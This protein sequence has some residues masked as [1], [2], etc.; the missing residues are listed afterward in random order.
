MK[1]SDLRHLLKSVWVPTRTIS[2]RKQHREVDRVL[3]SRVLKFTG[4]N[5]HQ[6]AQLLGIAR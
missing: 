2:M 6:A 4:G 3:L 1:S 5:Q